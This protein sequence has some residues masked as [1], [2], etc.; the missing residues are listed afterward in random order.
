[1]AP[2]F[3][4]NRFAFGRITANIPWGYASSGGTISNIP[5]GSDTYRLHQFTGPGT[6]V[7]TVAG[8]VEALVVAGGT[9]GAGP[10]PGDGGFYPRAGSGGPGGQV[11]ET[12]TVIN[13]SPYPVTV[14]PGGSF[15][16]GSGG[17]STFS[18]ITAT[19][20][21]GGAGGGGSNIVDGPEFT[22]GQNGFSGTTTSFT[23]SSIGYGGGGGG[24]ACPPAGVGGT[25][26]NGGAPGAP[27]N[28]SAGAAT[29]NRGGGGGGARQSPTA[30]TV[31]TN[32][33]TGFVA[34]RYKI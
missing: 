2:I 28:G 32:G 19:G 4:G 15:P 9:G 22:N 7:F 29:A 20:G 25:G 21:G 18:N 17:N 1:M 27:F 6:I 31:G 3:T 23:G 33:S 24:G 10:G 5:V 30:G 11:I 14:G 34:I 13:E 16:L 26:V 12:T 8:K